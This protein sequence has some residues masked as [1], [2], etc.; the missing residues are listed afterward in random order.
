MQPTHDEAQHTLEPPWTSGRC[1]LGEFADRFVGVHK[2]GELIEVDAALAIQVEQ[3]DEDARAGCAVIVADVVG[4]VAVIALDCA[5]E[6]LA[7]SLVVHLDLHALLE[8]DATR[9]A[10][11]AG[12]AASFQTTNELLR[13]GDVVEDPEVVHRARQ[14]VIRDAVV[15]VLVEHG[16][17]LLERQ[18][19]HK[20]LHV[21]RNERPL[22]RNQAQHISQLG[23]VGLDLLGERGVLFQHRT[24]LLR[25]L[26]DVLRL[27]LEA[28]DPRMCVH[29]IPRARISLAPRACCGGVLAR[30]RLDRAIGKTKHLAASKPACCSDRALGRVVVP[31]VELSQV[32]ARH[33]DGLIVFESF[34]RHTRALVV[35]V[36]L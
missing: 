4:A 9:S 34:E 35:P 26:G 2:F 5:S 29:H 30:L 17:D 28:G 36:G 33:G 25:L 14:L 3:V 21:S 12:T 8:V 1:P 13:H 15:A 10:A 16:K 22:R 7:L 6:H 24:Q 31:G 11:V 18:A 32:F 27:Q 23:R 20:A 19:L